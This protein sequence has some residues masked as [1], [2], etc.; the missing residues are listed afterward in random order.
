MTD[1]N[2]NSNNYESSTWAESEAGINT[3]FCVFLS[4]LALVLV[5]S[6]FLHDSPRLGAI[7]PEAGM[8]IIVGVI[9]GYLIYLSTP[10]SDVDRESDDDSVFNGDV[11]EHVAAGLLSFSPKVF[12]FVLLPPIIFNS[13]YNLKREVFFR[14]IS[15]ISLFACIG[16]AI[17][18]FVV[19]IML[20][21]LKGLDLTGDF[22]PHF[23]ELLA[24]GALIS[25]TDPVSTLAV[26]QA[27]K[28]DP[29]LFYLVFGESVLN[30]AVGLLLFKT[31]SKFV[32]NED[33]VE[34]VFISVLK[35]LRDFT[36]GF[37]GSMALGVFTGISSAFFFKKIEMRT[38]PLLELSLFYLIMYMPF[39]S[40]ELFD[41][42]GI[43]TILFTGIS[44]KRYAT[45]NLSRA[46]E[47]NVDAL[48][49]VTAHLAETCI[50]L[51]LGLS[52]FGLS[53]YGSSEWQFA[54]WAILACLIGRG[55]NIYPLRYVYNLSLRWAKK[56][57]QTPDQL[58]AI[59]SALS[60]FSMTPVKKK[61]LKIRNNT[62]HM[63][64]FSGLRG[65]VAYACAKTFPNNNG[66]RPFFVFATIA[67]VL[68]TVFIFGCTTEFA[69]KT[70]KIE[71]NVDEDA[72]MHL[73][74]TESKMVWLNTFENRFIYPFVSRGFSEESDGVELG[75]IPG[76]DSR[77]RF[78][79]K[80]S[81][82]TSPKSSYQ[83][84]HHTRSDIEPVE[85]CDRRRQSLYD[86]G[87]GI[88]A[89]YLS[90]RN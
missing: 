54:C 22:K 29:Q 25:A 50:F 56:D 66:N 17:S 44:A 53:Y 8:I 16:T 84:I 69:L 21:T 20:E 82:S 65:A 72:Y 37:A 43:V 36:I 1:D 71:T 79:T 59:E 60:T 61:D 38:T 87:L 42:S 75:T 13:G 88:S 24:F 85:H 63:L 55:L 30:D 89:S 2:S 31:L 5:L 80:S 67:I 90:P 76:H 46:T 10:L 64:W 9:A 4:L 78:D 62:A 28:V 15:P 11:S 83:N 48:F 33:N 49:R 70:L 57:N 86:F 81:R 23:T 47:V 52:V 77:E 45:Q 35:F 40:A 19:A 14:H 34:A 12:F 73:N 18:T 27:K 41:L 58:Q 68:F 6:K 39:F 7:I 74:D 26:F 51:E 32:G 3:Y